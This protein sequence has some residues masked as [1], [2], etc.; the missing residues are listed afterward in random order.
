M[1]DIDRIRLPFAEQIDFFRAKLNLPSE[2]WDSI[3]KA[4]HDRAFIVAGAQSADLLTDLRGAVDKSIAGGDALEDFRKNFRQIVAKH[5]WTG[6]AGEGTK[7][8]EAWRTKTIYATNVRGSH[9][10]GRY[11]QLTHP[12]LLATRPYWRY[13]HNDSVTHP[14]PQHAAWG[15]AGLTLRHDDPFWDTHYPPNGWGCRCSVRAV[16]AP[17]EDAATAP[18]KGWDTRDPNG[19]LP[20]IDR[21]WDYAPGAR[22]DEPLRN[23]VQEKLI[24]LPEAIGRA[25]SRDVNRYLTA[26]ADVTGF[27]REALA[28]AKTGDLWMGFVDNPGLARMAGRNLDDYLILLPGDAV[29]HARDAHGADTGAQR[30]PTPADYAAAAGWINRPDGLAPGTD[31]G[32]NGEPRVVA[33][34][35]LG[36]ET[37]ESVWEIRPGKRNRALVLISM[38]V[39]R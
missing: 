37:I 27:V 20:G 25:L 10:A 5:G 7:A 3:E 33:S 34:K 14:R 17:A 11:A 18:P 32:P 8:G 30:P 16:R 26:R 23:F 31:A 13:V 21:G 6:W 36:Q 1:P 12:D 29:R 15:H 28:G 4:A 24:T 35:R 39:K 2:R 22:A 38:W 19:R 9:A